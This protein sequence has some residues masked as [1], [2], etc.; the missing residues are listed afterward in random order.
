VKIKARIDITEIKEDLVLTTD[1]EV[2]SI[3]AEVTRITNHLNPLKKYKISVT[4]DLPGMDPEN[5]GCIF[6]NLN[7]SHS[8]ELKEIMDL[9]DELL[10]SVM[11]PLSEKT[12]RENR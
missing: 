3:E 5:C 2:P 9:C 10:N 4:P 12:R 11:G 6:N 1:V 7:R 8:D